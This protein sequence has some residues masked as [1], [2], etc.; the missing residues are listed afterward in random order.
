MHPP[1]SIYADNR[2][3][4]ALWRKGGYLHFTF[5]NGG[6]VIISDG[7]LICK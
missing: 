7:P 6:H 1:V 4:Y 5:S 2:D 3:V